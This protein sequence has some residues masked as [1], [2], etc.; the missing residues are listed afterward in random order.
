VPYRAYIEGGGR[1]ASGKPAMENRI[2][3]LSFLSRAPMH[4]KKSRARYR[5]APLLG[6]YIRKSEQFFFFF[7]IVDFYSGLTVDNAL[8]L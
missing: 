6:H 2:G 4:K 5:G 8:K 1:F 7:F 3:I